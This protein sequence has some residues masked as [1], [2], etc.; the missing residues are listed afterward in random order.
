MVVKLTRS[1]I[2]LIE[3]K[4]SFE[5]EPNDYDWGNSFESTMEQMHHLA[6]EEKRKTTIVINKYDTRHYN[7]INVLA[8]YF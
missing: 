4:D 7:L 6:E 3:T 1:K 8:V 5:E 2:V